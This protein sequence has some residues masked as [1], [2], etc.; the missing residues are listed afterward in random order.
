MAETNIKSIFKV[1]V[2]TDKARDTGM[3]MVLILL[4]LELFIKNGIYY[5][6]AIPVLIVNMT[7]P[8]LFYPLAYLWFGLAHIIGTI[9]SKVL[10][11]IVFSIIVLPMAI[12]RRIMGKDSLL[13]KLWKKD[14]ESV[15]KT[16]DHLF[17]SADIEKPY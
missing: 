11:F 4:L 12:L 10:L 6:I 14:S 16:R 8:Q 1:E 5:K 7:A 3:A 15:F 9:V 13:I 17:V 2:N